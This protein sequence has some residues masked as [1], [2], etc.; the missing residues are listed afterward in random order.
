[1]LEQRLQR[2]SELRGRGYNCAQCVIMAFNDI[3]GLDDA[4]AAR[5]GAGLGAGVAG[6]G[7]ICG[8]PNAIAV[9]Q[10]M[11]G[12]PEPADKKTAMARAKAVIDRFAEANGGCLR[13][14]DLKHPGA[15]KGC[16]A[17]IAEGITMLHRWL[18][19]NC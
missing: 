19:Q 6:L 16:D 17:L 10:G 12:G 14:R 11:A 15:P 4:T 7:E 3:T 9:V 18:E 8:V 1:M 2:A 13:C 5:I